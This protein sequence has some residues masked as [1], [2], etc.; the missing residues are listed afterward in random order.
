MPNLTPGA[1][2]SKQRQTLV[3]QHGFALKICFQT[4]VHFGL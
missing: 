1:W 2:S 3:L 4:G